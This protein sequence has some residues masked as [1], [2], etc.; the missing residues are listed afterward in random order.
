MGLYRNVNLS[1]WTD[2]KVV[3]DFT[4]EDRF[5]FLYCITNP[6][7]NMCGCYEISIKQM[8]TECGYSNDTI[9][10]LLARFENQHGVVRYDRDTKELLIVNWWKYNWT[11]SEKLDKPI[12]ASI[13]AIKSDTFR[14]YLLDVFAQRESVATPPEDGGGPKPA[15][16][17]PTVER[18]KHGEHGWVRLSDKEFQNLLKDLGETELQRCITY[19]DESAQ[20]SGNK[21]GWKDWNLVLRRCHREGWGMRKPWQQPIQPPPQPQEY[22][23]YENWDQ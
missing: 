2:G 20:S 17:K 13:Q 11:R 12:L 22:S 10:H 8:A 14:Q 16:P 21:N 5:F 9:L 18:H 7:T 15:K 6:H 3:D 4:P 1:F 19:I 23:D